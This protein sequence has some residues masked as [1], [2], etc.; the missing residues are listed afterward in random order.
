MSDWISVKDRLPERWKLV[1]ALYKWP[2]QERLKYGLRQYG[3][4]ND[5]YNEFGQSTMNIWD[6]EPITYWMPLPEP[7]EGLY[8]D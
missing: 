8:H 4:D 5:W 3:D 7:P 6:K 1:L 2:H